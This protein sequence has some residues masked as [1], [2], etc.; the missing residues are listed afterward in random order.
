MKIIEDLQFIILNEKGDIIFCDNVLFTEEDL[1]S[2]SVFEWSPFVESIFPI[3]L[4]EDEKIY[5]FKRR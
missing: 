3:L 4:Q 2:R 1:P 5:N